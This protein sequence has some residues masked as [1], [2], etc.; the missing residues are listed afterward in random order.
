MTHDNFSIDWPHGHVTERGDPARIICTD[1]KGDR[2]IIALISYRNGNEIV[3]SYT[4]EGTAGYW[5]LFNKK[6]EPVVTNKYR[7]IAVGQAPF[8]SSIEYNTLEE[9]LDGGHN[10]YDTV[11]VLC[12][13]Y[14][15][16]VLVDVQHVANMEDTAHLRNQEK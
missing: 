4:T 14:H 12:F 15:D 7:R 11:G 9:A 8:L 1:R 5:S 3:L 2:P 6:P 10:L 13:I 16:D